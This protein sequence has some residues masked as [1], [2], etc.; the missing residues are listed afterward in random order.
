MLALA[1]PH[2]TSTTPATD[3]GL[4]V[5][6]TTATWLAGDGDETQ[7]RTL[8][9]RQAGRTRTLDDVEMEPWTGFDLGSDSRGRLV[10]AYDRCASDATPVCELRR[11]NPDGT[12]DRRLPV[13]GSRPTLSRGRLAYA[14][15]RR[16]GRTRTVAQVVIGLSDQSY[17][18]PSFA[19]DHLGWYLACPGDSGGCLV[20]GGS[21]RLDLRTG[22]VELARGPSTVGG[23][24]LAGDGRATTTHRGR[25]RFLPPQRFAPPPPSI[26]PR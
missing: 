26:S 10:L 9:V 4:R 11:V 19:G 3:S 20:R 8:I 14:R 1:T 5:H 2:P 23:F 18:G 6:G 25:V 24:A 16:G 15:L 22:A 7:R 17:V 12:G 21:W 13:T